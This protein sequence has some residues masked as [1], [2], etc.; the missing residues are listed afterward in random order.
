MT[1]GKTEKMFASDRGLTANAGSRIPEWVQKHRMIFAKK[2]ALR[3]YYHEIFASLLKKHLL[4]GPTLEIGSG[5]GFLSDIVE[6]LITSDY[7]NLPGIHVVCDAHELLFP[8]QYFLNVFFVDVLHHLKSPLQCFREISRVLRPGGRLVM[9]EPYTTPL[10]RI[11][12]KF[13][14]HEDCYMPEDVWNNAF[15]DNKEP[16]MGNTEIPRACLAEHNRPITGTFPESGLRLTEFMPFAGPSYF[17][18]GGFQPWQFPL[19]LIQSLYYIESKTLPIWAP[20]AATRCLAVLE[21]I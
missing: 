6:D 3:Y 11:V 4:P 10:S 15:P 8:D 18:T 9:I 13:I 21:K 1:P 19:P 12:Y 2:K 5:P 16:M 20:L 17:L 14:H 7:E